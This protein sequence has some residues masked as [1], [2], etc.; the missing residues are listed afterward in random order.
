MLNEETEARLKEAMEAHGFDVV[1]E[2]K[3]IRFST[4]KQY[5]T[6]YQFAL[7][8]IA[9]EIE[10]INFPTNTI[11]IKRS[12]ESIIQPIS[13]KSND[14]SQAYLPVKFNDLSFEIRCLQCGSVFIH[15]LVEPNGGPLCTNCL[16][17]LKHVTDQFESA[18]TRVSLDP[19]ETKEY[20]NGDRPK[21]DDRA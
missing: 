10:Y 14:N 4:A 15:K 8:Q 13:I 17:A 6:A 19:E 20:E 7:M 18:P 3:S 1:I 5:V 12:K 9:G 21:A 11:F 2:S 16:Q